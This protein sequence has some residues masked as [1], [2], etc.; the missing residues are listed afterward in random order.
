VSEVLNTMEMRQI[1][2]IFFFWS[3]GVYQWQKAC[4]ECTSPQHRK[5]KTKI[6][7]K[8]NRKTPFW[9][10]CEEWMRKESKI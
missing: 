9:L 4:L 1:K 8:Q 5:R 10:Y 2:K 6:K 7:P 3:V